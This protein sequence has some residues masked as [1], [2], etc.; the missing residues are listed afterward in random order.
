MSAVIKSV[1]KIEHS[2]WRAFHTDIKTDNSEGFIDG[3]LIENYLDLSED[4]MREV[5][6]GVGVSND[7]YCILFQVIFYFDGK[8][9]NIFKVRIF[10]KFW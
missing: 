3:D 1:G 5:A 2:F 4:N 10:S 6:E 9:T 7:K 8:M